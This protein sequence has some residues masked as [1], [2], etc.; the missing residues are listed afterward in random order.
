MAVNL[1]DLASTYLTP[2]VVSKLAGVIGENPTGT[3]KAIE[4]AVPALLGGAISQASTP[5]G[6]SSLMGL[7]APGKLDPSILANLSGLLGGGS[8][9]SNLLSSGEG[10]V[11]SLF[12]DKAGLVASL[13][14]N[15]AGIKT[16]SVTSLLGMAAPIVMSLLGKQVTSGNLSASGLASLLMSQKDQI[17]QLLPA[18]LGNALGLA[19]LPSVSS[20]PPAVTAQ[21]SKPNWWP[22][23]L[24]LAAVLLAF[25]AYRSCSAP[26][27]KS[28]LAEIT[29]PG[30]VKISL[31]EGTLNW[32]LAKFL[33]AGPDSELPKRFVFDHLNFNTGSAV[34]T[35]ESNST[36]TNLI[37]ILKAYPSAT[38][39]LEG[40]TDKTGSSEDNIRLSVDRAVAVKN[41]LV[42]GGVDAV[43][44][45][46]KGFGDE[47]PI[48]PN[49]TEDGRAKNR[50]TEL[51]VTKR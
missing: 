37:A 16:S 8:S 28:K 48:A 40:H 17:S 1:I 5:S 4:S 3:Q 51:V 9:T 49:D 33:A 27:I 32:N 25:L 13:L 43:R 18:G 6:L 45:E 24:G 46:A 44:I 21:A 23:L 41:L 31:E 47:R 36:V 15:Q 50:R 10:I 34:L 38:I 30:G 39:G 7:L 42:A 35:P 11:K 19:S 20:A 26:D 22:W 2:D 12:G 14:G 29:L